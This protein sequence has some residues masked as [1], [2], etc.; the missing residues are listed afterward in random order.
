ML[1]LLLEGVGLYD[2]AGVGV[3]VGV[4]SGVGGGAGFDTV[5]VALPYNSTAFPSST[6]VTSPLKDILIVPVP[7]AVQVSAVV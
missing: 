6:P 4:G 5:T 1:V 3:G 7:V 2:G